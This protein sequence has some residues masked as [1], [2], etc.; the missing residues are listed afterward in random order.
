MLRGLLGRALVRYR[1]PRGR[2]GGSAALSQALAPFP[3]A[4]FALHQ[5]AD[6]QFVLRAGS[7]E[8]L[9][10]LAPHLREAIEAPFGE[11]LP[12]TI[13]PLVTNGDTLRQFTSDLSDPDAPC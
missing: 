11:T 2:G 7:I 1:A 12:L 10:V 8:P 9:A 5:Q 13:E 6:G 3:L 4:R